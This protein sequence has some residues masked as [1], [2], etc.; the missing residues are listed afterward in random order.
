MI[1]HQ[2]AK[3][4]AF[5]APR[6]IF[7]LRALVE[8]RRAEFRRDS[9]DRWRSTF[10][11]P[12]LTATP[13]EI[14]SNIK[15]SARQAPLSLA[16]IVLPSAD[17]L[18][19]QKAATSQGILIASSSLV[20]TEIVQELNSNWSLAFEIPPHKWEEIIA[21]AFV[22]AGF[23][24]VLTPRSGDHG[25]DVIA[26]TKGIGSIKIIGS[27]KAYKPGNLVRYDDVRSLLGVM[28]AELNTSKGI[29]TTTSDFPAKI[30]DDPFIAP[31]L[32]TRLELVNGDSLQLW[33]KE[34][35]KER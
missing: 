27:V 30:L 5:G 31:F 15:E 12:T 20:W 29:I 16:G 19:T 25:R 6:G 24:V 3:A 13:E 11:T 10:D 32:P 17:S 22:K 18:L 26:S 28:S 35:L 4:M 21:G 8:A 7:P 9:I 33:L 34:L 14:A 2:S 1:L 23:E